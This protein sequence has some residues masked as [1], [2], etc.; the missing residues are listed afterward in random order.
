MKKAELIA[1]HQLDLA[2]PNGSQPGIFK[3]I[4]GSANYLAQ[5][6]GLKEPPLLSPV[7][8]R[9]E[10]IKSEIALCSALLHILTE[11]ISGFIRAGLAIRRSHLSL[12]HAWHNYEKYMNQNV[13]TKIDKHTLSGIFLSRGGINLVLS[14]APALILK[15]LSVLGFHGKKDVGIKLLTA[16]KDMNALRSPF[17]AIALAGYFAILGPLAPNACA[18]YMIRKAAALLGPELRKYPKSPAHLILF[19]R[20]LRCTR[21]LEGSSRILRL[22]HRSQSELKALV[23]LCEC[24]L[25]VSAMLA[26]DWKRAAV[27]W[28]KL[29]DETNWS[30]AFFAFAEASCYE[31][32]GEHQKAVELFKQ[33]PKFIFRSF[34]GKMISL[35]TYV[36]KKLVIYEAR[37]FRTYLPAFELMAFL[38]VFPCMPLS[39]LAKCQAIVKE[40]IES[41]SRNGDNTET[42]SM[43][44]FILG[45]IEVGRGRYD[46]ACQA[47]DWVLG[48][49]KELSKETFIAPFSMAQKALALLASEKDRV[50]GIKLALETLKRASSY[51]SYC[52]E[53]ILQFWIKYVSE[54]LEEFLNNKELKESYF[55]MPSKEEISNLAQIEL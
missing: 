46:N 43:L 49:E 25:A 8:L 1:Q 40:N 44:H 48:H 19:A 53:V 23:S 13:R 31:M 50:V 12:E 30:K 6:T 10:I 54:Q 18:P 11:S 28:G 36:K 33:A 26:M 9:A 24:E 27:L 34:A 29:K 42:L 47:F 4:K 38:N 39:N 2:A 15:L 3:M 35:E 55:V 16:S 20:I 17:S 51:S 32:N 5:T 41:V 21:D 14:L 22:A 37:G 52:H 7:Q 45:T